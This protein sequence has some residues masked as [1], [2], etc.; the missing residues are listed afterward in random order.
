VT[1]AAAGAEHSLAVTSTGQLYAFGENYSGEL[2]NATNN[3]AARANPTPTLVELPAGTTIN[4]LARGPGASDTLAVTSA[5]I[6]LTVTP[7][8]APKIASASLTN[9]R[10]RVAKQ[11]IAIPAKKAPLG[12]GEHSAASC[13]HRRWPCG[14]AERRGRGL[15]SVTFVPAR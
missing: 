15:A 10:L 9:R 1:E 7:V 2:G 14:V 5:T 11:P 12:T 8:K 4:T 13:S 6:P 3:G